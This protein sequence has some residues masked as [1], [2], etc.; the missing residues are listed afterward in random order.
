MACRY[1]R[2]PGDV[3]GRRFDFRSVSASR[4]PLSSQ[5]TSL[6]RRVSE[7]KLRR[8]LLSRFTVS[9]FVCLYTATRSASLWPVG[10]AIALRRAPIARSCLVAT[11]YFSNGPF[12]NQSCAVHGAS[13]ERGCHQR[14]AIR[15][16]TRRSSLGA[17]VPMFCGIWSCS[18]SCSSTAGCD[19]H[20]R[21]GR[22][23]HPMTTQLPTRSAGCPPSPSR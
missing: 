3:P 12:W 4:L 10:T 22:T 9:G 14:A 13:P 2:P 23:T 8:E 16:R 5:A 19:C 1:V 6:P 11:Y 18:S 15:R 21:P 20:V 17:I 7:P